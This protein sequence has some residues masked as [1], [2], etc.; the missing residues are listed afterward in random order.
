MLA[1]LLACGRLIHAPAPQAYPGLATN[2]LLP[3]Y[4][5]AFLVLFPNE[6]AVEFTVPN[7][8]SA[9]PANQT[10]GFTK[11]FGLTLPLDTTIAF[12]VGNAS[13]A[14][15][16][17]AA[18]GVADDGTLE[19]GT[20]ATIELRGDTE[21]MPLGAIRL[22]VY[23]MKQRPVS[24]AINISASNVQFNAL[25]V[26]GKFS[27]GMSEPR[28]DRVECN[29][30]LCDVFYLLMWIGFGCS[31][32]DQPICATLWRL[33]FLFFFFLFFGMGF[34]FCLVR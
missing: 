3:R 16:V 34:L 26:A 13:A 7:N 23:H 18:D 19:R 27:L 1:C 14:V 31:Y 24:E 32:R 20:P 9:P 25:I 33:P 6:T 10:S 15:R 28:T 11:V 2:V 5:D 30:M 17:F 29:W 21:G 12:R 22:A 8:C 4:A